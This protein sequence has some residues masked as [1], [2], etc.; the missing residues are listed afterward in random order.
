MEQWLNLCKNGWDKELPVHFFSWGKRKKK[1]IHERKMYGN[2][3]EPASQP[4]NRM[5]MQRRKIKRRKKTAHTFQI[6]VTYSNTYAACGIEVF[7]LKSKLSLCYSS[8]QTEFIWRIFKA[9]GSVCH[10]FHIQFVWISCNFQHFIAFFSFHSTINEFSW[11]MLYKFSVVMCL[12][13]Q[14]QASIWF[15][16]FAVF[17]RMIQT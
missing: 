14:I 3:H 9:N 5:K 11:L 13:S 6:K 16:K 10:I 1:I 4:T 17:P 7:I 15:S 8:N 2:Q 12:I